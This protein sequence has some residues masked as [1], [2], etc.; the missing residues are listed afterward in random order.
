MDNVGKPKETRNDALSGKIMLIAIVILFIVIIIMLCLHVYIRWYLVRARRRQ[1]LNRPRLSHSH[2]RRRG[3]QFV[4]FVNPATL[5][6]TSR[7]LDASVISS[8]PVFAFSTKTH[9]EA[10]ECAV[11]LS[12]FK[13]GE[14]G[15]VLPRCNHSFHIDCIDMWFQSHSTCP[16]CRAPVKPPPETRPEVTVTVCE[17]ESGSSSGCC[18]YEGE[19]PNRT[20]PAVSSSSSSTGFG[21]ESQSSSRSPMSRMLSFKRILSRERKARVS[22]SSNCVVGCSSMAELDA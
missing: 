18:Q 17:P 6:L 14:T 13:D 5:M 1:L 9:T 11:C 4:F 15:R 21:D 22:P 10:V 20:G 16:L 3:P 8:L 12:E 7:G 19:E 2:S